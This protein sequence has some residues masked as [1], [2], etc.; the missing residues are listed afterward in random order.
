MTPRIAVFAYTALN[1]GDDL[2][3][4]TLFQR[5]PYARFTLNASSQ[6]ARMFPSANIRHIPVPRNDFLRRSFYKLVKITNF[7]LDRLMCWKKNAAV[8]IAGSMFI[9]P[10]LPDFELPNRLPMFIIGANYG[11]ERTIQY[12]QSMHT[13]FASCKDVCF[14]DKYSQSTFSDLTNVRHAPDVMFSADYSA[15]ISDH[16]SCIANGPLVIS[17]IDLSW[18]KTLAQHQNSY[19]D[20][21]KRACEQAVAEKH[22]VVL[23]SFCKYE[24]DEKACDDLFS[25]LDTSV[26]QHTHIYRYR[27]NISS[28]LKVIGSGYRVIGSR[29]HSIVLGLAMGKQVL[30]LY[31]SEK[32]VS[33]LHDLGL[34]TGIDIASLKNYSTDTTNDVSLNA[35]RIT[36]LQ[37]QAKQQFKALDSYMAR[38]TNK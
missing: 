30:P 21:L 2:F 26:A 8:T 18:R 36:N 15:Y 9:D 19:F 16:D 27:G 12:R 3:L 17:V 33:M 24:G 34:N 35:E 1:L 6:Y 11:P 32:T 28:A 5:Y 37:E 23:M 29:F 25:I 20:F 31:Y 10:N 7:P 14:R 13:Y 4:S 38:I 22:E